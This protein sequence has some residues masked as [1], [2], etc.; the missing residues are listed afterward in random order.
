MIE[1]KFFTEY[2]KLST[3]GNIDIIDITDELKKILIQS[4]VDDG[5]LIVFVP[6]ATGAV[7]TIEC[8]EGL[9]KDT[10]ELFLDLVKEDKKYYHN[11]SHTLGNATSHLRATLLSPS[12]TIPIVDGELTLGVWQQVVFI[13]FDNR[14]RQ[15]K[16]IVKIIGK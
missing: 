15:R 10:K 3:K 9:I 16:L 2:I 12:L 4:K 5:I 14:P 11:L 1:N 6:G 8:E 13:D 7:A